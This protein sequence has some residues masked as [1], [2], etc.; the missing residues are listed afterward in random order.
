MTRS[1]QRILTTGWMKK[2]KYDS[3]QQFYSVENY[4]LQM[5]PILH[6]NLLF[7]DGTADYRIPP[8]PGKNE[9]VRIRFRTDINNVDLIILHHEEE[10]FE[11]K[12][13]EQTASLIIM[14]WRF[15]WGR[16]VLII[17]LR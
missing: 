11:M 3:A 16:S 14:R 15:S 1:R 2:M 4:I 13:V 7:S 17:I 5:R 12:L 10:S 9:K 6:K 8:E